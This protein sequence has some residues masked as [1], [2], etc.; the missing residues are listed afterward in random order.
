MQGVIHNLMYG[1]EDTQAQTVEV[2]LANPER[3]Q[4]L[5]ESILDLVRAY[6]LDGINLDLE[7]IDPKDQKLLNIFL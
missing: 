3:R 4:A 1:D 5:V 2:A 7:D 6:H